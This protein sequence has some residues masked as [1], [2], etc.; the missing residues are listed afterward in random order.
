MKLANNVI[1][2]ISRAGDR[3]SENNAKKANGII[4]FRLFCNK[5]K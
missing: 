2:V 5:A 1:K 3:D 4:K